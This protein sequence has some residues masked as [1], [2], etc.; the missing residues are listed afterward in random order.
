MRRS[1]ILPALG[2][3]A[4]SLAMIATASSASAVPISSGAS[5]RWHTHG[6][7]LRAAPPLPHHFSAPYVDVTE[8]H[9]LAATARRSGSRY[10]SLA[11]LKTKNPGSCTV[12][13]PKGTDTDRDGNPVAEPVSAHGHMAREITRIRRQGGD[14]IPSFGG[15]AADTTGTELADSCTS[16]TKIA[17]EYERVIT[18]LNV[19]R[20]D[21]DIEATAITDTAG[22]TRRNQAIA[23]VNRWAHRTHR[24]VQIVYTLPSAAT[25][26]GATGVDVLTSAAAAHAKVAGVNVMT[27]D[28]YYG[29]PQNMLEDSQTAAAGL[30]GQLRATIYPHQSD[31]RIWRRISVTQMNGAD[32]YV[33]GTG[34]AYEVFTV[35]QARK[36][37]RWAR[38]ADVNM[39]SFWAL[40]RDNGSCA[41]QT[42]GAPSNTCSGIAQSKWAFSRI[43]AT[44]NPSSHG[45]RGHRH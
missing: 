36:F 14:V 31:R 11:F 34:N 27:F 33:F 4:A 9:D 2:A 22:V 15:Y 42:Q 20:L 39:I 37:V 1:R 43:F 26:L 13:W 19:H 23:L 41:G 25:G 10:L 8:V 12:Y 5:A 32:D 40:Q 3:L 35:D 38:R 7:G 29:T 45:W 28:Y 6:P 17:R 18:T 24:D 16:V 44:V 30:V 21:F